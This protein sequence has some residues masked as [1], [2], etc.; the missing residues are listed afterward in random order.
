MA[1]HRSIKAAEPQPEDELSVRTV[2]GLAVAIDQLLKPIGG[3]L[4]GM[5]DNDYSKIAFNFSRLAAEL[6]RAMDRALLTPQSRIPVQEPVTVDDPFVQA[7]SN[8]RNITGT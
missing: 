5:K 4:E 1:A 7:M 8:V 6:G 3:T 2:L